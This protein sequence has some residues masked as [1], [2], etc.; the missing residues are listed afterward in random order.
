[1]VKNV[2][3]SVSVAAPVEKVFTFLADPAHWM[4]AVPDTDVTESKLTPEGVG[5][6]ARWGAR[7]LGVPASVVQEYVEFVPNQRIV[8]KAST[9]YVLTFT[10]AGEDDGTRL[11]VEVDWSAHVPLVEAPLQAVALKFGG[12]TP[13]QILGNVKAALESDADWRDTYRAR[14]SLVQS[15]VTEGMRTTTTLTKSIMIEAPVEAVFDHL[16][17]PAKSWLG[18]GANVRDVRPTPDGVGTTFV[19][20]G[21]F[22][23]IPVTANVEFTEVVS[24][25]RLVATSSKG[26]VF[27]FTV[28]PAGT[29]TKLT[30]TEQDVPAN[31][32]AAAFDAVAMRLTERDIDA[33]LA[34]IKTDIEA[35]AGL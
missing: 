9:G 20:D 4:L 15:V 3:R 16:K 26:F 18:M 19:A 23:G 33:S 21:T 32:A 35:R 2:T 34:T 10:T 30:L 24:N 17:D 28:E 29:G 11:T 8:S 14:H 12:D 22:F 25:E 27:R 5:T 1:M 7:I 31:L 6:R 13:D